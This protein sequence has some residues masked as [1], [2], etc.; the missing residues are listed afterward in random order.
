MDEPALDQGHAFAREISKA[1]RIGRAPGAEQQRH[2][3]VPDGGEHVVALRAFLRV[4]DRDDIGAPRVQVRHGFRPGPEAELDVV[5][6]LARGRGDEA[7]VEA[8]SHALR[9]L[10][11]EGREVGVARVDQA[12]ALGSRSVLPRR[13]GLRAG[14]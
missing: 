3:H 14:L 9:V 2:V 1:L 10:V 8:L 6:G 7:H 12:T 11:L 13:F 5:A 4:G